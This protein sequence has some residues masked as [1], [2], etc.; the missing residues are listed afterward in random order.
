MNRSLTGAVAAVLFS[1]MLVAVTLAQA[2]KPARL[3][4]GRPATPDEIRALDIDVMP[5]GIGLPE[6]R[7]TVAEGAAIYATKCASCHGPN[8]EN[9]KFDRLV[10]RDSGDGF[11]F[12]KDARLVKTIGNYWPYATTLYD[13]TAR[14]MPFMQPGTLSAN[15]VYGLVAYLLALNKIVPD[16]AVMDKVTLPKVVMPARD[17]FVID[18]RTG[19]PRV[20]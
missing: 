14:S 15:E 5:S 4:I 12:A 10:G 13:Y 18:N 16:T 3:G 20:K 7:G 1:G 8:G 9:G 19:G 17:R 11:A 6:G 2:P